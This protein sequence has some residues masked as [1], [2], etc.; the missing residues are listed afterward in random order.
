MRSTGNRE[1]PECISSAWVKNVGYTLAEMERASYTFSADEGTRQSSRESDPILQSCDG[2]MALQHATP[3]HTRSGHHHESDQIDDDLM[4]LLC[5]ATGIN[6]AVPLDKLLC[7][8]VLLT[9]A[10]SAGVEGVLRKILLQN[11]KTLI[12]INISGST[13][14]C[15]TCV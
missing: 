4:H 8:N 7:P 10:E 9:P 13:L 12:E 1:R 14:P 11:S 3:M 2:K 15:Q 6:R 5:A